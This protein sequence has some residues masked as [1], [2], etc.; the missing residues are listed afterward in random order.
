M[1]SGIATVK[2]VIS[3][4]TLV[5]VGAPKGGPPPEKRVGLSC[6][7]APRVALKSLTHE[8]PDEPYGWPAREL[9][10]HRLIGQQVE[11]KVEYSIGE[12]EYA[13]V[14]FQALEECEAEAKAKQLGV[15]SADSGSSTVRTIKWAVGEADFIAEFVEKHKAEGRFFVEIRLLNRDVSVR[16]EGSDDYGNMLGTLLHPKGDISLL[17]L[18]NGFAKVNNATVGLTE[19][20]NKLRQAMKEAQTNKLR[21][22]KDFSSSVSTDSLERVYAAT[23]EEVFSGDSILLRLPDGS[24][25]RVYFA[26][27]RCNRPSS[28]AKPQ[29]REDEALALEAKELVRKK[30]IGKMVK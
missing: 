27:I 28:A 6:V 7:V 9:M 23:V 1:A 22:W 3:G 16:V 10:R 2:E 11:F 5:L 12:K 25:R 15:H 19:Q 14:R 30:T 26:S 13:C 18:S 21:R 24:S 20:P 29:P 17:L 4:D 8:S